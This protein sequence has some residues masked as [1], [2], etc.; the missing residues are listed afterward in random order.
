ML[1]AGSSCT[2][3]FLSWFLTGTTGIC[4]ACRSPYGFW[5]KLHS[6][7]LCFAGRLSEMSKYYACHYEPITRTKGLPN[8]NMPSGT[9]LKPVTFV[10]M[11]TSYKI[12]WLQNNTPSNA[13]YCAAGHHIIPDWLAIIFVRL[14]MFVLH[15]LRTPVAHK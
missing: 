8:N 2:Q 1:Q 4:C 13:S 6:L 9:D 11:N 14:G 3:K 10:L 5:N 7:I 12:D 15:I